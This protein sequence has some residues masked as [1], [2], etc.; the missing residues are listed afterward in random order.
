VF[1]ELGDWTLFA[2]IERAYTVFI[3]FVIVENIFE[4]PE[5]YSEIARKSS[6]IFSERHIK[7]KI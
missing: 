1:I 4:K 3:C 7:N 2:I 6:G 5:K